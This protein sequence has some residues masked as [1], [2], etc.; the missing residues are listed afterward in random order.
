M[1]KDV[2]SE[3]NHCCQFFANFSASVTKFTRHIFCINFVIINFLTLN[4]VMF[5]ICYIWILVQIYFVTHKHVSYKFC[6]KAC[7]KLAI[8]AC[9][10]LATLSNRYVCIVQCTVYVYVCVWF[11]NLPQ[12]LS[13]YIAWQSI[14]TFKI[15]GGNPPYSS[16]W[17]RRWPQWGTR[18]DWSWLPPPAARGCR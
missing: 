13:F 2:G 11:T 1:N 10:E 14:Y 15:F 9:Q 4:F 5:K 7:K 6:Y 18:L 12:I 8:E 17:Q 16:P 3:V